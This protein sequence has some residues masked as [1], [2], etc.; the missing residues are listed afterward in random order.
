MTFFCIDNEEYKKY[1]RGFEIGIGNYGKVFLSSFDN[2]KYA[3]KIFKDQFDEII[4][5]ALAIQSFSKHKNIMSIERIFFLRDKIRIIMPLCHT[6]LENYLQ[7]NTCDLFERKKITFQVLE[8]LGYLHNHGIMHLDIKP[9]N[10]LLNN[11]LKVYVT[12][13]DLSHFETIRQEKGNIEVVTAPYRAPEL[14]IKKDSFYDFKVDLW[15]LGVIFLYNFHAVSL[16]RIPGNYY[17]KDPIPGDIYEEITMPYEKDLIQLLLKEDPKDRIS[18]KDALKHPFFEEHSKIKVL[19]KSTLDLMLERDFSLKDI[20]EIK[21]ENFGTSNNE[22]TFQ[23]IMSFLFQFKRRIDNETYQHA[24]IL[25]LK[26]IKDLGLK[27]EDANL[28]LRSCLYVSKSIYSQEEIINFETCLKWSSYDF[29]EAEKENMFRFIIALFN[30]PSVRNKGLIFP[31]ACN[32]LDLLFLTD[33][34]MH[35][36]SSTLFLFP[37]I[38]KFSQYEIAC[39]SILYVD[40]KLFKEKDLQ[41]PLNR[42]EIYF[43][44]LSVAKIA[45]KEDKKFP[46]ILSLYDLKL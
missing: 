40:E 13:F 37:E 4:I 8:A 26:Y 33:L 16:N 17:Y 12:D 28:L 1:T 43:V 31:T 32:F 6:D 10:I 41:C 3:E 45:E 2:R 7:E 36:V 21:F 5:N 9:K 23:N 46:Q 30:C 20:D 22:K 19:E 38:F 44:L 25:F 42:E 39:M 27:K 11:E 29:L 35:D 14:H 15:S 18:A 24:V 34:R